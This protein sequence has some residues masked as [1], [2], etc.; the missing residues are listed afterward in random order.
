MIDKNEMLSRR[1]DLLDKIDDIIVENYGDDLKSAEVKRQISRA[2]TG[3]Y[4]ANI[5]E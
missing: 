1:K 3:T 5:F 2:V 4:S